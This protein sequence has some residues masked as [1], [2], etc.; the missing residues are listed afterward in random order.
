M[1]GRA[2]AADAAEAAD[3]V[4]ERVDERAA[5]VTG[6]RDGRPCPPPCR[7]PPG[8]RRRTAPRAGDSRR[9]PAASVGGGIVT[10]IVMPVSS[11]RLG[12]DLL[13][14]DLDEPGAH[15]PLD[16][17]ARQIGEPRGQKAIEPLAGLFVRDDE[18]RA[19]SRVAATR[20][21]LGDIVT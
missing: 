18:L 3:V 20:V 9:G 19:S 6:A 11:D 5:R 17:R 7:P 13:T 16:R 10:S 12:C 21:E 15:Q 8:R 2:I 14:I 4:Q 1:P